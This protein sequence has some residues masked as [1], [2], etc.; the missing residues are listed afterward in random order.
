MEEEKQSYTEGNSRYEK[1][2]RDIE[3]VNI[4]CFYKIIQ[5]NI[6]VLISSEI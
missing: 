5:I 2:E 4:K 3:I 6:P 1:M